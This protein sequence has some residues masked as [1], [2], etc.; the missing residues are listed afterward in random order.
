MAVGSTVTFVAVRGHY[1]KLAFDEINECRE[2]YKRKIAAKEKADK[3]SEEKARLIEKIGEPRPE[4]ESENKNKSKK[5]DATAPETDYS[6]LI[7]RYSGQKTEKFNVFTNPPDAEKIDNDGYF[8]DG[9]DDPYEIFVDHSGPSEGYSEHPYMISEDEFASEKLFY[10]K[11]MVEYY[12][13]GI[14]VLEETDEIIDSL[15]DLIGPDILGRPVEEDAIYVRNDNRS[16]D[17]GI[18]FMGR[19]FVPEEGIT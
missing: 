1:R 11:V 4:N 3:N 8:G 13:D 19:D 12:D 18:I 15:E 7:R 16:T 5:T 6:S 9:D 17:Y 10:D 14:A 2:M